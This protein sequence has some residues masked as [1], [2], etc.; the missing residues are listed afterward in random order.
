MFENSNY[1]DGLFPSLKI[2]KPGYD[3]Y[4][5]TTLVLFLI[6]LFIFMFYERYTND[7]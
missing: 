5:A 3:L 2:Q 4:G 1:I 6:L 7:P